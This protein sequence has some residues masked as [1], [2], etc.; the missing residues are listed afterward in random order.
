[1][2]HLLYLSVIAIR[3]RILIARARPQSSDHLHRSEPREGFVETT[4]KARA[5]QAAKTLKH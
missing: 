4:K 5:N 2:H 3:E 1:M